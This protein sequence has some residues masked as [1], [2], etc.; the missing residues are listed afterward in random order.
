MDLIAG[1]EYLIEK[2]TA[3]ARLGITGQSAGGIVI[4]RAITA[5]PDLF[6]AAVS[7]GSV[8]NGAW[9]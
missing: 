3:R 5:R 9:D 4:G 2:S 1:A 6:A 7:D 8:G